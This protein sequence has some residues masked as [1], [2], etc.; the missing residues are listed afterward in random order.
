[1]MDKLAE[2]LRARSYQ[3]DVLQIPLAHTPKSEILLNALMWRMLKIQDILARDIDVVITTAFPA[4]LIRHPNK[5]LW[6]AHQLRG[7]YELFD[8]DYTHFR[9]DPESHY[10]RELI[11]RMDRALIPEHRKVF[12]QSRNIANRLQ[13]NTGLEGEVLYVPSIRENLSHRKYG[14]YILYVGRF[15]AGKRVGLMLETARLCPELR[16]VLAGGGEELEQS[17]ESVQEW[18]LANVEIL[19]YVSDEKIADLYAEALAV[20]YVPID[21]DY[22]LVTLEAFLA[23]KPVITTTDSGGIAE[24]V[25][26]GETGLIAPPE[27]S[28]IA[29]C[30]KQLSRDRSAVAKMGR[31]AHLL[32]KR[33]DWDSCIASL[34]RYF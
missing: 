6:L 9:N 26:H 31:A 11:H 16:F 14:D 27:A 2:H 23:S 10:Y 1:M 3:A 22:G 4:Y 33:F 20:L 8:T 32:A 29:S 21:E 34:E 24:L 25:T 13:K 12:C 5:I 15:T 30:V 28:Q 18:R 19:G 7:A 17:R